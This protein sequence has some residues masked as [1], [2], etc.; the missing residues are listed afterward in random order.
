MKQTNEDY[1]K[2]GKN[3]LN[4]GE[5]YKKWTVK[6]IFKRYDQLDKQLYYFLICHLC[7]DQVTVRS[8]LL[9]GTA[10]CQCHSYGNEV[11]EA[12]RT[13]WKEG[14]EKVEQF[15]RIYALGN[16]K[17]SAVLLSGIVDNPN[18]DKEHLK[19]IA[20]SIL[21]SPG[22]QDL[23]KQI[24]EKTEIVELQ[25]SMEQLDTV[26]DSLQAAGDPS[27]LRSAGSLLSIKSKMVADLKTRE[28]I[29][30]SSVLDK[31]LALAQ[32]EKEIKEGG[33]RDLPDYAVPDG[34]SDLLPLSISI[35]C[36]PRN[37]DEETVF[38]IPMEHSEELKEEFGAF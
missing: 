29:D 1:N 12:L 13:T 11:K 14:D 5:Q 21:C 23:Y 30:P 24:K 8:D 20:N 27:S 22:I 4:I 17:T 28:K 6:K 10:E 25:S 36:T 33:W 9:K 32:R 2:S 37:E 7:N 35:H 34:Y 31:L 38:N 19:I 3:A 16:S 15:L 18:V 26:I